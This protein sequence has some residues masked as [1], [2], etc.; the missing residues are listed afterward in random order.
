MQNVITSLIATAVAVSVLALFAVINERLK[1]VRAVGLAIMFCC[2]IAF[3]LNLQSGINW[4]QLALI[5]SSS[6]GGFFAGRLYG[7][8]VFKG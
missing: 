6:A 5:F 8:G 3:V 4:Q 1:G 7:Y 2:A